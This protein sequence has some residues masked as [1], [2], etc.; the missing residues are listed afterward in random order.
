MKASQRPPQ[1]APIMAVGGIFTAA[2]AKEKLAAGAV[3][4][5]VYT[6]FIYEGPGI[7]KNICK[8]LINQLS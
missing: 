4:V 6:G 7:A 2:D 5:Q 8:G 1:L 3:L